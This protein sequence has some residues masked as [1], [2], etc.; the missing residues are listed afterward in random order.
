M[1]GICG[2]F[3]VHFLDQEDLEQMVESIRHRGPDDKGVYLDPKNGVGLGHRR[4]SII[5]LTPR[6]HQPMTYESSGYWI[7][8]NGEVYNFLELRRELECIGYQF[9]S[10]SD[11]EVILAGYL[12]WGE[13][14]FQRFNGM[15]ALAIYDENSGEVLLCRDRYGIKPLYYMEKNGF[16]LFAS[17][18]KAFRAISNKISLSWDMRGIVTALYSSFELEASGYTQFDDDK[19]L[20]SGHLLKFGKAGSKLQRWWSTL[21]YLS[22]PPKSLVEQASEFF[23][24]F[25]DACRLR[26]RSDVPIGTSLSGGLDSS[27]VVATVTNIGKTSVGKEERIAKNWHKAFLHVFP[28]SRMDESEFAIA[29]AQKAGVEV[30]K[31]EA[32]KEKLAFDIDQMVAHLEAIYP[33]MPDSLWRIYQAQR[34]NGV[35][36]TLDGHGADEMLGGYDWHISAAMGSV[37]PLSRKYWA[38]LGLKKETYAYGM[39]SHFL[40]RTFFR[41]IPLLEQVANYLNKRIKGEFL[42]KSLQG[43]LPYKINPE[44]LPKHWDSLQKVLYRDFHQL[45]L[46]R[47]LKN[48][49]VMSMAHGVEVRMPFMDYRLVNFVFSLPSSS[50]ISESYTKVVLR[51]AMKGHLPEMVRKRKPKIGFNSPII[52]WLGGPLRGW[53]SDTLLTRSAAS[54]V[55]DTKKLHNYFHNK[56][57]TG[58]VKYDEALIF[59]TYLC[60][61]KVTAQ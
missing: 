34:Q 28:G 22:V 5:D 33:G 17:E 16:L 49:D 10:D 35:C 41:S 3:N 37:L 26:M 25:S 30:V 13:Q 60:A 46:P 7:V 20:P 45:I 6:G 32:N 55:I 56:I 53:V 47:I 24:L 52:E 9:K 23:T 43:I 27:S 39:P 2:F 12:K 54:D 8:F 57:L 42:S 11:T 40:L 1:C 29:T 14:A 61:L 18:T 15:W 36:V 31:V 44:V 50:K 48:F 59:W 38:L 19:T 4:L 51:E 21:D 58:K